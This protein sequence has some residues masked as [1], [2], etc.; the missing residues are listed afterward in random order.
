MDT[1]PLQHRKTEYY[2]FM[3][4]PALVIAKK[5]KRTDVYFT[6]IHLL[7]LLSSSIN[8]FNNRNSI[9]ILKFKY[10][11]IIIM[12]W[13]WGMGETILCLLFVSAVDSHLN[14]TIDS[15]TSALNDL[16]IS[17]NHTRKLLE[18]CF[19][20][21]M[22]PV[23]ITKDLV[24]VFHG[25]T[26]N[27]EGNISVITID[28]NLDWWRYQYDPKF[29][30]Y[31]SY[32]TVILSGDSIKS[33]CFVLSPETECHSSGITYIEED[34]KSINYWSITTTFLVSGNHC[35]DASKALG[36]LWG[37]EIST[38]YFLCPNE[39]NNNTMIYTMNPFGDRAPSP[40]EKV[41]TQ[42][43]PC[44]M[45]TFYRMSFIND[46]E[47]CSNV[48][49]DKTEILN[50]YKLGV[51]MFPSKM[52]RKSE[53]FFKNLYSAM[54]MTPVHPYRESGYLN[55]ISGDPLPLDYSTKRLQNII[56]YFEQGGYVIVTQKQSFV[57]TLDQVI[58]SFF[59]RE[60]IIMSSVILLVIFLMMFLNNRYDFGATVLDLVAFLL[61]MGI[62][63]PILRLS[64]RITFM[65]ATLFAL[66]FNPVLQGQVTSLL[67][68]PGHRNVQSLKDL[69]DHDYRVYF[70]DR[71]IT[72]KL[73][74]N[75]LWDDNYED[76]FW[77]MLIR[78]AYQDACLS[79]VRNDSSVACILDYTE[80]EHIDQNLHYS[81]A[82]S[83]K[84]RVFLTD[85]HFPLNERINKIALKLFETGHLNY[86]ER[87]EFHKILLERK[88]KIERIKEL[89]KHNQLDLEDFELIYI[90]MTLAT[91]WAIIVFGIEVL[92]KKI[93]TFLDKRAK[94]SDKRK[95]MIRETIASTVR[96]MAIVTQQL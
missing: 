64:M 20:D 84:Y 44:F 81:K 86:A 63:T 1:Y 47:I 77:D 90:T 68:R 9:Y 17:Q 95:L 80:L 89:I 24:K 21:R 5:S 83:N 50:G 60:R 48:T 6:G 71:E 41:E 66:I 87:R 46:A 2:S 11:K 74:E 14:E 13:I 36:W 94:E 79:R 12:K 92:I 67:T 27:K 23:V 19:A 88:R 22:N 40:W 49:F 54:N 35:D 32:S 91:A 70:R 69:I 31:P 30:V 25:I 78:N 96:R 61:D 3:Y 43:K 51:A 8:N 18:L 85:R 55:L 10:F 82:F 33:E 34:F 56:P 7:I 93:V 62:S 75:R 76:H 4:F 52:L 42:D 53:V 29:I 28:E 37:K 58:D 26:D 65:S 16:P 15:S 59:T 57:P 39:Y 72:N 38:S 73:R 45:C